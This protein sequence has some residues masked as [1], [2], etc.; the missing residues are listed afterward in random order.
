MEEEA[1][2]SALRDLTEAIQKL[3]SGARAAV[4]ESVDEFVE[5][6]IT[7]LFGLASVY[8]K[9]LERLEVQ[10]KEELE[11]KLQKFFR[12]SEVQAAYDDWQ[13]LENEWDMLLTDV[14]THL[15]KSRP[16]SAIVA[17]TVPTDHPLVDAHTGETTVLTDVLVGQARG[18]APH[19]SASV[20]SCS[21]SKPGSKSAVSREIRSVVLVL[22][23]HFA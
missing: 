22:L 21:T 4:T 12:F 1:L 18:G 11:R 5:K 20:A 16:Q 9:V 10:T 8:Q 6:K 13:D 15:C 23:R 3:L 14:D 17:Q 2:L 19:G 7:K